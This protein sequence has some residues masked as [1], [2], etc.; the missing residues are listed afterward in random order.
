[1]KPLGLRTLLATVLCLLIVDA[2]ATEYQQ[3]WERLHAALLAESVDGDLEGAIATF[4]ALA[5]R[6]SATTE[7]GPILAEALFQLG[8]A[9]VKKGDTDRARA[10]LRECLRVSGSERCRHLLSKI[11]LEENAISTLPLR[12]EFNDNQ[13]GFVLIPGT[14]SVRVS[15]DTRNNWLKWSLPEGSNP[16][17]LAFSI[18]PEALPAKR[19]RFVA[20]VQRGERLVYPVIEDDYGNRF[21]LSDGPLE[22]TETP[23]EYELNLREFVGLDAPN[24]TL[25]LQHFYRFEFHERTMPDTK[26]NGS[27]TLVIDWFEVL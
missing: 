21:T 1:M 6:L 10:K 15:G 25:N 22:L 3:E 23:K 24:R 20:Y 14:G 26:A 5:G 12:W 4:E 2:H 8:Y 16:D 19:A 9:Y 17:V 7:T 27:S 11:A 18:R 13:H